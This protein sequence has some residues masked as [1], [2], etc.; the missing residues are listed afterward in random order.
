MYFDDSKFKFM[1]YLIVKLRFNAIERNLYDWKVLNVTQQ[2]F[3]A[4]DHRWNDE[5][6][7]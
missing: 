5:T 6:A 3:D 4:I 1:C 2:C 7:V